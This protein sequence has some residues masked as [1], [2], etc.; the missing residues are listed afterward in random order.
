MIRNKQQHWHTGIMADCQKIKYNNL[1]NTPEDKD[2]CTSFLSAD[3]DIPYPSYFNWLIL[4]FDSHNTNNDEMKVTS[5]R[6]IID[7]PWTYS[8]N[9]NIAAKAYTDDFNWMRP[10]LLIN[11]VQKLDIFITMNR[12]TT[13]SFYFPCT[14]L[15]KGDYVQ[16][17][18]KWY[19]NATILWGLT[20]TNLSVK[21]L[22]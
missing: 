14:V 22:Q 3:L 1:L 11:W 10:V 2:Y 20:Y 19:K 18:A 6:I 12:Q 17:R 21:L 15:A 8:I 16:L 4:P 5:G 13:L 7:T 9:A